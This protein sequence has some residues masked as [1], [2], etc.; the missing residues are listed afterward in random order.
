MSDWVVVCR[1][2]EHGGEAKSRAQPS[3]EAAYS[4]ARYTSRQ[5]HDVLRIEGPNGVVIDKQQI[6]S[7]LAA[8]LG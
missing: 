7:W 6:A 4:L 3:G 8:D 5:R 2:L 1:D